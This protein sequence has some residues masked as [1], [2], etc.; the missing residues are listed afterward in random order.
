[1]KFQ[2]KSEEVVINGY[3]FVIHEPSTGAM[4][5]AAKADGKTDFLSMCV[6]YEGAPVVSDELPWSIGAKLHEA[7]GRFNNSGNESA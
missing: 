5:R 6:T 2:F 1:M 7:V 3:T 4:E